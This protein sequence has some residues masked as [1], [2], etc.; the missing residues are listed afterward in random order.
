MKAL[1][2]IVFLI[3]FC[4]TA[5]LAVI[6]NL[7]DA[8]LSSNVICGKSKV[9]DPGPNRGIV[10]R[11]SDRPF[12][13]DIDD[14]STPKSIATSILGQA[15]LIDEKNSE[16]LNSCAAD[17][18]SSIISE[19]DVTSI[20]GFGTAGREFNY[21]VSKKTNIDIKAS[22]A[23]NILEILKKG[24]LQQPFVDSLKTN[25]EIIY[26]KLKNTDLVVTANYSEWSLKQQ[27]INKIKNAPE[28]ADCRK[29]LKEKKWAF[30][31]DLGIVSYT[32]TLNGTTIRNL[33]IDIKTQL[34]ANGLDIDVGALIEKEIHKSLTAQTVGAYQIIGWRKMPVD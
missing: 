4:L 18:Y 3:P 13:P 33:G 22:A 8:N 31:T 11:F 16:E 32:I 25:L 1:F 26:K 6:Y 23:A 24:N 7:P 15:V 14:T 5:Q 29:K 19:S 12:S 34:K 17:G 30:I 28:F 21:N 10:Y 9:C 2:A 27:T 20:G